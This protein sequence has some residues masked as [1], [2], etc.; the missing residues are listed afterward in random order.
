MIIEETRI[1]GGSNLDKVPLEAFG[2]EVS[3]KYSL[4]LRLILALLGPL[5]WIISMIL[6]TFFKSFFPKEWAFSH[7]VF[8]KYFKLTSRPKASKG[9]LSRLERWQKYMPI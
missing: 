1:I 8:F 4:S 5:F 7:S 2:R 9:T 3:L 6:P